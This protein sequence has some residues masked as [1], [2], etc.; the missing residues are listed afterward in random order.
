PLY[1]IDIG[2]G[3]AK[4]AGTLELVDGKVAFY[5]SDEDPPL[6]DEQK[7]RVAAR[8]DAFQKALSKKN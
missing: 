2:T 8:L 4:R 5:L 6:T 3:H 1:I 7:A